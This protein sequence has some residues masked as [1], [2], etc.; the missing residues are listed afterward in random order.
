M[1]GRRCCRRKGTFLFERARVEGRELV[2]P[3]VCVCVSSHPPT[4]FDAA[5]VHPNSSRITQASGSLCSQSV[6]RLDDPSAYT[7]F[8]ARKFP[9]LCSSLYSFLK[10]QRNS[11]SP[12]IFLRTISSSQLEIVWRKWRE[13]EFFFLFFFYRRGRCAHDE[14]KN[15][16][17][18]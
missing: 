1:E 11:P 9:H 17:W 3:I 15:P 5:P 2:H 16:R 6:V 18:H 8:E 14:R 4:H 13:K 10:R 7:I 12:S